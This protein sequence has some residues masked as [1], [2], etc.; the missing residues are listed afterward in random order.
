MRP[1]PSSQGQSNNGFAEVK[2]NTRGHQTL[3][4]TTQNGTRICRANVTTLQRMRTT[5]SARVLRGCWLDRRALTHQHL[6]LG[7]LRVEL[8]IDVAAMRWDLQPS[9]G[10][11]T[12]DGPIS[13]PRRREPQ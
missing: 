3:L 5:Y 2:R 11:R 10:L 12:E 6:V 9:L 4:Q 13:F 8:G 1:P 7:A